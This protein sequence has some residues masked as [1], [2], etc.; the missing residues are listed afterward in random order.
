VANLVHGLG[1]HVADLALAVGGDRC[2]LGDLVSASDLTRAPFDVFEDSGHS[3][4]DAA[5]QLHR[6]DAADLGLNAPVGDS[7]GQDYGGC[8]SV[9][10]ELT[11]LGSDLTHH[12]R[13]HILEPVGKLDLFGYG[14]TVLT[15]S[16]GTE[17]GKPRA[18]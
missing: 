4:V 3:Q 5:L 17:A 18:R 6:V 16:R 12:L 9:A 2:H 8:G 1:D 14:H 15:D 10:G 11:G 7:L 13:A